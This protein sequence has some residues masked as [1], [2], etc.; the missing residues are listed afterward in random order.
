MK[1]GSRAVLMQRLKKKITNVRAFSAVGSSRKPLPPHW[2][3]TLDSHTK[4]TFF[5]NSATGESSWIRP[6]DGADPTTAAAAAAAAAAAEDEAPTRVAVLVVN[7]QRDF[8]PKGALPVPNAEALLGPIKQLCGIEGVSVLYVRLLRPANHASFFCNNPGTVFGEQVTGIE[9]EMYVGPA[10]CVEGTPGAEIHPVLRPGDEAVVV[11]VGGS[12]L[13]DDFSPFS[14]LGDAVPLE[15]LLRRQHIGKLFV[16]GIGLE[17]AVQVGCQA[18]V[19]SE[20][21]CVIA[22]A[23]FC[24]TCVCVRVAGGYE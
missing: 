12:P 8:F 10:H 6:E 1:S 13:I 2:I 16:V 15:N 18:R 19:A 4:R 22:C 7:V 11:D 9:Q 23:C 3:A 21:A 17:T 20:R 24:D 14:A 5:Y